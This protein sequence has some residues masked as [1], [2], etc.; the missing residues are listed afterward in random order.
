MT[1]RI[2]RWAAL[3]AVT[4]FVAACSGTASS[5]A[6]PAPSAL[7]GG[8]PVPTYRLRATMTQAVP[9]VDRF[10]ILPAVTITGDNQVVVGGPQIA[11]YP[12]PL[13]PNLQARPITDGGFAK[14][15]ELGRT[16]GMFSG[17]GDFVPPD[18]M[19]GAQLG[20]IEIVVDGV[21]HDLTGDPSRVIVCVT[22]PCNPAP[23]TP[24]AFGSF[25]GMLSDLTWLGSDLGQE[26]PY[27]ADAYAIL[28]GIQPVDDPAIRPGL[29]IWPL[30][31][32]P[33]ATLGKPVGSDSAPRC[34]TVRGADA[35]T[36]RPSLESANQITRWVDEGADRANAT[37][38]QVRPMV[39]GED[40]CLELFGISE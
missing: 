40:V 13:L 38:I 11:I 19:P 15:V 35:A 22:T 3:L 28:V 9:P 20:R 6:P 18:V 36:L 16:L 5:S 37:A 17:T 1:G 21:L 30:D 26:A 7:P 24:E 34:G 10:G 4:A 29:A 23:G 39:P 12:G 27:V 8:P 32:Q 14:I 25:W 33:I 31:D 2:P